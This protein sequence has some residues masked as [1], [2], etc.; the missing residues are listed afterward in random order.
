MPISST[1]LP[2][3]VMAAT[4][5]WQRDLAWCRRRSARLTPWEEQFLTDLGRPGAD[6]SPKQIEVLAGIVR[7][8]ARPRRRQA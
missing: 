2:A 8:L 3:E 7:K 4:K 1:S 6:P 5:R